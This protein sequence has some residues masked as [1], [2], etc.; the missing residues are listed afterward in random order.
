MICTQCNEPLDQDSSAIV[1]FEREGRLRFSWACTCHPVGD[2][3]V[4]LGSRTCAMEWCKKHREFYAELKCMIDA[5]ALQR[6]NKEKS[7]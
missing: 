4:I 1:G 3:A 5:A 2:A 7:L 6:K